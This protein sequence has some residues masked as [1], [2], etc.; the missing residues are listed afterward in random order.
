M[1]SM[2]ALASSSV[3]VSDGGPR[4]ES[5]ARHVGG[6]DHRFDVEHVRRAA[7]RAGPARSRTPKN[8]L[9]CGLATSASTSSTDTSFSSAIDSA[10]LTLVKVLPSPG[11]ALATMMR[12]PLGSCGPPRPSALAMSGRLIWRYSCA[13]RRS[14]TAAAAVRGAQRVAVEMTSVACCARR[15]R[16]RPAPSGAG[17]RRRARRA[18]EP[19]GGLGSTH[20]TESAFDETHGSGPV[21]QQ[22]RNILERWMLENTTTNTRSGEP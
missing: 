17:L 21:R 4:A 2:R 8:R 19:D 5:Q 12:W 18:V 9:M 11:S 7:R 15:A 3:A 1:S 13:S 6:Q 16:W 14:S 10:R 20:L 22:C